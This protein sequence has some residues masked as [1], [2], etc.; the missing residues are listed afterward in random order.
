MKLEKAN[1]AQNRAKE[2]AMDEDTKPLGV[3]GTSN[4]NRRAMDDGSGVR[5]PRKAK[6]SLAGPE[7]AT[8]A[9][10]KTL[11][12]PDLLAPDWSESEKERR[13]R[14]LGGRTV[15]ANKKLDK[16]LIAW[17]RAEGL[18]VD[19]DRGTPWGNP[20]KM[21]R[22]KDRDE[23]C[24]RYEEHFAGLPD[25]HDRL[26]ELRGKVLACW[27]YPKRCHAMYLCALASKRK[28]GSATPATDPGA[29]RTAREENV[30]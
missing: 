29:R 24:D 26:G 27:C 8:I 28:R 16:R 13:G 5:K 9:I 30:T 7:A 6:K 3:P 19:V 2:K 14:V 23:V 21:A 18:L 12:T 4:Q 11:A 20:Y 15:V 17:A 22:E 1:E 25:I 10:A